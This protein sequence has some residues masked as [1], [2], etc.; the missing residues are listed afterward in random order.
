MII[1]LHLRC[2]SSAL[3]SLDPDTLS[4]VGAA[5]LYK[6]I[7]LRT[8]W[9]IISAIGYKSTQQTWRWVVPSI[10]GL[11]GRMNRLPDL[12]KTLE[13]K[14]KLRRATLKTC[15]KF[16]IRTFNSALTGFHPRVCCVSLHVEAK[17]QYCTCCIDAYN[18]KDS[19]RQKS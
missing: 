9:R 15:T 4:R 2:R 18:W 17:F 3:T 14:R 1:L 16:N 8:V 12:P 5:C 6:A 19:S 7:Q 13:R 11:R 10:C